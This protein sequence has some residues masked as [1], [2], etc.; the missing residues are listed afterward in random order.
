[1][2][3][4]DRKPGPHPTNL[5][6]LAAAK[7]EWSN[8]LLPPPAPY[9]EGHQEPPRTELLIMSRVCGVGVEGART[10]R[11]SSWFTLTRINLG[12]KI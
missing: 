5:K 2:V 6:D 7:S 12:F 10:E 1:M 9:K 3:R 4:Q 8:R 11:S